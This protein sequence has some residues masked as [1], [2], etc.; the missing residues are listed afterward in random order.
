MIIQF[1]LDGTDTNNGIRSELVY[2]PF[3]QPKI[4]LVSGSFIGMLL[5]MAVHRNQNTEHQK[6]WV[7]RFC[8]HHYGF[9]GENRSKG[10]SLLRII[11]S[12]MVAFTIAPVWTF[13]SIWE[14]GIN[15]APTF[16]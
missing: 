15:M 16:R 5:C 11:V 4:E 7:K 14:K 2:I 6:D 12:I 3:A 10:I 8:F 13:R 1:C 9:K